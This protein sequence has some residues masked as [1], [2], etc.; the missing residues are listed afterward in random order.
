MR[1]LLNIFICLS[2]VTSASISAKECNCFK[3]KKIELI[4]F[5]EN[6]IENHMQELD[7][8]EDGYWYAADEVGENIAYIKGNIFAYVEVLKFIKY[9][10]Y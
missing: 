9:E 10:P 3:Y 1:K 2:I 8:Y 7:E 4:E 6:Q 5:I